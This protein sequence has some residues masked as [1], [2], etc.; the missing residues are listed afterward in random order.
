MTFLAYHNI[1]R[2][3]HGQKPIVVF[4]R[5]DGEIIAI[6]ETHEIRARDFESL[7]QQVLL[8]GPCYV[9]V[10]TL[11]VQKA[12]EDALTCGEVILLIS[13]NAEVGTEMFS[14]AL[15]IESQGDLVYETQHESRHLSYA[16][17]QSFKAVRINSTHIPRLCCFCLFGVYEYQ[18]S[19]EY[20]R[21]HY[22]EKDAFLDTIAR[23]PDSPADCS[24]RSLVENYPVKEFGTCAAFTI[25]AFTQRQATRT[26]MEEPKSSNE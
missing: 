1:A 9:R 22:A 2:D 25:D 11:I 8:D 19:V 24:C 12:K 23:Q 13:R 3:R 17:E 26:R 15:R 16:L 5:S 14:V 4:E 6:L 20:L 10:P 21:C 7:L 18:C